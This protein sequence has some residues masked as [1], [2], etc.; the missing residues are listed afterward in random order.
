MN[1]TIVNV[2]QGSQAWHDLRS[3]RVTASRIGLLLRSP[4][5]FAKEWLREQRGEG[6]KGNDATRYGHDAEPLAA[7]WYAQEYGVQPRL[8]GFAIDEEEPRLGC[9]PDRLINSMGG[10]AV[11]EIKCPYS[12]D[13]PV[14]PDPDHVAQV[15]CQL[16]ILGLKVGVLLYW[17]PDDAA[18]FKVPAD[19]AAFA[20]MREAV[21]DFFTR[22]P[23]FEEAQRAS[24]SDSAW[25]E[26]AAV[27][28]EAKYALSDAQA[29]EEAARSALLALADKEDA[30]GCGVEVRWIQRPG[31]VAWAKLA[32]ELKLQKETVEA[33]RGEPIRYAK[34]DFT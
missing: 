31:T 29:A 1:S 26:A 13:L 20:R 11:L 32:K 4:E 18:V 27:W 34:V 19:P 3:G 10:E 8:I 6:F 14:E 22:L 7:D 33:F 16:G 9:S 5:A 24:R 12:K 2:E 21:R 15:Q 17:T 25:A 30:N 28:A 23:A